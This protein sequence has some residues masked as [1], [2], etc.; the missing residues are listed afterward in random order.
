MPLKI[1]IVENDPKH[2]SA[3]HAKLNRLQVPVE[4]MGTCTNVND[5]FQCISNFK[6]HLV[7]LD[8]ELDFGENGFDLVK[9][10]N[11]P[12]FS[13][14]FTTQFNTTNNTISAIRVC[15]FDFLPKP[16]NMD[17]LEQAVKR[18]NR[19]DGILQTNTFK[20]NI[21]STDQRLKAIVI[22]T[23]EGKTIIDVD[24]ILFAQSSGAYTKFTLAKPVQAK[25]W[26]Q[27]S[28]N[29]KTW[30]ADLLNS[31]IVRSHREWLFNLK[32]FERIKNTIVGGAT[33][34]LTNGVKIPVS[35]SR[36]KDVFERI[37]YYQKK[38]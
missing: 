28:R 19:Q 20:N 27:T 11:N 2:A 32:H 23:T 10:F 26:H 37:H 24:N 12:D 7:F 4:I 13:V 38:A 34:I 3:L 5:A 17:E 16:V 22:S 29:I 21:E 9:R 15:A 31:D 33:I 25:L 14:I 6:P 30:E 35:K 36:K 8:I 1:V 18:Y